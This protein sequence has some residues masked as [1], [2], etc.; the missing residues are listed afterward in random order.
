MNVSET[1]LITRV[2]V[3][4]DHHAFTYL[5]RTHQSNIRQLL[6]RWVKYNYALADDL[7]QETFIQAY[8]KIKTFKGGQ[9]SAWLY[10]IAYRIF[11]Q[12]LRSRKETVDITELPE[13]ESRDES[14]MH[15]QKLTLEKAL[16]QLSTDQR[17]AITLCF[18]EGLSQEEASEVMEVPLG[19]L[20]SHVNRGKAILK[21][22]LGEE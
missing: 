10:K 5:V 18:F 13:L 16:E 12:D 20:K 22:L 14:E 11:L 6:R 4:D 21:N 3:D 9:F 15:A 8:R 17:C 2:I 1:E 19:T 7:A